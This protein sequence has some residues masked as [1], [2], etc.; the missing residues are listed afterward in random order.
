MF[1]L[2][3]NYTHDTTH[4]RPQRVRELRASDVTRTL[5]VRDRTTHVRDVTRSAV[6]SVERER[7]PGD[8]ETAR[9]TDTAPR[10]VCRDNDIPLFRLHGYLLQKSITQEIVV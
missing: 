8:G 6:E 1:Y 7:D 4:T 2:H 9:E 3:R 5:H 10:C